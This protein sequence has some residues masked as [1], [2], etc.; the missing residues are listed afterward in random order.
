M[1]NYY[2]AVATKRF[3]FIEEPI[4]EIL[5]ERIN[6]YKRIS[7]GIDFWLLDNIELLNNNEIFLL[8]EQFEEPLVALISTNLNFINWIK[9]R[10][11]YIK[12]GKLQNIDIANLDTKLVDNIIV[13][14]LI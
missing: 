5:R 12:T 3:L 9:L 1:K 6:Y 10:V 13:K 2:Y 11:V 7:K 4:E 8:Q 14:E